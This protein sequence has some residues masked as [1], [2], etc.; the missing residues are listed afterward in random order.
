MSPNQLNPLIESNKQKCYSSLS[1]KL[2]DPVT[3]TK[4]F[5]S[6]LKMF[7]NNKGIL[8]TYSPFSRGNIYV[9]ALK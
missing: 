9:M 5:K 2:A 8:G 1:N 7:L 4:Y 3:R 6:T